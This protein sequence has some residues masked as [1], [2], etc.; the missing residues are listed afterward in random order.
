M[1]IIELE[2]CFE[3]LTWNSNTEM[4]PNINIYLSVMSFQD[5]YDFVHAADTV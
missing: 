3:C 2:L 4:D 1:P 5:I